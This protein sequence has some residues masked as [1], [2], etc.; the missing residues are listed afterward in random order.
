MTMMPPPNIPPIGL[1][2]EEAQEKF[3]ALQ[4]KLVPLWNTLKEFNHTEQTIVVVP[5]LTSDTKKE[6][7]EIQAY[8]ERM[9]FMLLLL[10][11]PRARLVYV[12]S[13]TILPWTLEYYLS[14]MPG[15]PYF[16]ACSRFFNVAVEDRSIRPLTTK[17]LERPSVCAKIRS[18]IL[19]P[20]RAHLVPYNVTKSERDLALRLGIP[21]YGADPKYSHLGSKTGGRKVF[22]EVSVSYPIGYEDLNSFE[23]VRDALAQVRK[24]K[25]QVTNAMVKLNEAVGGQGNLIVDL[26]LLPDPSSPEGDRLLEERIR[27]MKFESLGLTFD[28]FFEKL[29]TG[30]GIVEERIEG[31]EVL[32]PSVQMRVTPLGEVEVLSSHDQI[33]GGQD[34]Q[35]FLGSRFPADPRYGQLICKEGK[36]VGHR[37]AELGV[38]GRFAVDFVVVRND[39]GSWE[40][41]AIEI[42]LRKGGTTHP[43]LI[44]QFL[45]DGR[46]DEDKGVFVAPST[47]EK[48]YIS[49]DTIADSLYR[50][51]TPQDL[52]ALL[53][54]HG[55]YFN[56]ARQTGVLIHMLATIGENG[57]FGA[58]AVEDSQ[59][60]ALALFERFQ[61]MVREEAK[62][63]MV[64]DLIEE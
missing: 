42:N 57:K 8:E 47:V 28:K 33:L 12:T 15:I 52:I 23:T 37:L 9:L 53:I 41:Y 20:E 62:K 3:E 11:Q 31:S 24:Q 2:E 39:N 45:T 43:Y 61:K 54:Q 48:Y 46:F 6:G 59:E 44:L 56:Q 64:P 4:S 58:V 27:S 14:L 10:R 17:L 7:A 21:I 32:S 26:S 36:K 19:N 55:F 5:S 29:T 38:I 40:S 1:S 60:K 22:A 13:Q 63:A 50:V 35:S 49:K 16:H 25:P 18:L 30:G 51:F 34:D